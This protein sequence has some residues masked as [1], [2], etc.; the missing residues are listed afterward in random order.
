M[1]GRGGCSG[2]GDRPGWIGPG[3]G[4]AG[5]VKCACKNM[6]TPLLRW[7]SDAPP[8]HARGLAARVES[9]KANGVDGLAKPF[10]ITAIQITTS[11]SRI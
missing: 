5:G 3:T 7:H 8:W 6:K 2:L 9:Y 10:A 4:G 11:H 1:G